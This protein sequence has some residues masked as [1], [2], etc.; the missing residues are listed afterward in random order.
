[1]AKKD[2]HALMDEYI[3][4][5]DRLPTWGYGNCFDFYYMLT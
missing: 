4:R 1:M 5:L 2:P 3:A